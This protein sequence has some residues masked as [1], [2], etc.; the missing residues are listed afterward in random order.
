MRVCWLGVAFGWVVRFW[1]GRVL[2]VVVGDWFVGL[3]TGATHGFLG[4]LA[5]CGV[6]VI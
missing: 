5:E 1:F 3:C 6:G 4:S 2:M